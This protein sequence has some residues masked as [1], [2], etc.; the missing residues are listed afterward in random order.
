MCQ[1]ECVVCFI[2]KAT[3][4]SRLPCRRSEGRAESVFGNQSIYRQATRHNPL[5]AYSYHLSPQSQYLM[6]P[7]QPQVA[8]RLGSMGCQSAC[9]HGPLLCAWSLR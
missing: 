5:V 6:R 2:D 7:S 1:E 3:T 4:N 8:T 9:M